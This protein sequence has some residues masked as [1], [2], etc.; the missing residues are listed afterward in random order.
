MMPA[1]YADTLAIWSY[2]VM[3][4]LAVGIFIEGQERHG[5]G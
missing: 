5:R 3:A 4:S 1:A 2:A